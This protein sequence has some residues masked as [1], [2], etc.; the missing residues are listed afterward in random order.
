MIDLG[1]L[2]G[3]IADGFSIDD[4][5]QITGESTTAIPGRSDHRLWPQPERQPARLPAHSSVD[6]LHARVDTAQHDFDGPVFQHTQARHEPHGSTPSDRDRHHRP[7]RFGVHRPAVVREPCAGAD[8]KDNHDRAG[9]PDIGVGCESQLRSELL[10]AAAPWAHPG[11]RRGGSDLHFRQ[12]RS[13]TSQCTFETLAHVR[14]SSNLFSMDDKNSKGAADQAQPNTSGNHL[15]QSTRKG[16]TRSPEDRRKVNIPPPPG[17]PVRS[18]LDR[19]TGERRRPT[20]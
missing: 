16:P 13:A 19:R 7:E 5:G 17:S 9:E 1:T 10:V 18:G 15:T 12:R 4:S 8:R 11:L 14:P 20:P 6:R 2:G 3:S